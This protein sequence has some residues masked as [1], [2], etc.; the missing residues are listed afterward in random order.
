MLTHYLI[1]LNFI[2]SLDE[3][4]DAKCDC[5]EPCYSIIYSAF[6]MCRRAY[7]AT[8]PGSRLYIYYTSKMVTNIEERPGYD[9]SQ[10]VADMGGSLGFLLGLSVIGLIVVL[11]KLLGIWFM[12]KFIENYKAKKLEKLEREEKLEKSEKSTIKA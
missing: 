3:V 11:E 1:F 8:E 12:N 7:K 2:S 4:E 5:V 6:V 10:F 9:S